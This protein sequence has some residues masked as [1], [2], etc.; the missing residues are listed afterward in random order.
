[1]GKVS[2]ILVLSHSK[3]QNQLRF[4]VEDKLAVLNLFV[5]RFDNLFY[6][7]ENYRYLFEFGSGESYSRY[8]DPTYLGGD[9]RLH[10]QES[11][12]AT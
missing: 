10:L 8:E 3:S 9:E 7:K 4:A 2:Q 12:S 5:F 11:G 1:M 6:T